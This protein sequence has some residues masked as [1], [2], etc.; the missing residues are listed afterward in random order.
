[1]CLTPL[2]M[3]AHI[4]LAHVL[5]YDPVI[6]APSQH[7]L[8]SS[9]HPLVFK[10][11]DQKRGGEQRPDLEHSRGLATPKQVPSKATLQMMPAQDPAECL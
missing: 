8:L 5:L 11:P 3:H 1:M 7:S 4:F 6:L 10:F 2:G 9:P